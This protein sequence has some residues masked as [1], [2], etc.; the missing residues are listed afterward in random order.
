MSLKNKRK[1][2]VTTG[3]RADYGFLRP[4]LRLITKSKKLKLYLVVTGTHLSK[5]HGCTI[6]EIQKDGFKIFKTINLIP[7]NDTN[8]DMSLA[9]GKGIIYFSK[10]MKTVN[11]DINLI[12]GDR[13]EMLVSAITAYH[14]NIPN[15]HIHGGDKSK[16]GIDEYN[17]H[18]ITKMSNL[19]FAAT[20]KSTQRILKM[21]ENP[22]LVF[23]TGSPVIDEIRMNKITSKNEIEK[24]YKFKLTGDEILL[25]Q[26]PVTTQINQSENQIKNTLTAITKIKKPTIAI[27]PNSDAGHKKIFKYL[28]LYSK[29]YK[30]F[31]LFTNIPHCD[32]LGFLKN[33]GVLVGNS[34]SGMIE[35]SYFNTPVVNIGIRQ[36]GRESGPNVIN[37]SEFKSPLI[38]KAIIKIMKRNR[39]SY[40]N[41]FIYGRGLSAIK[42]VKILEKIKLDNKLIQKQIS[43]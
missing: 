25:V 16:G 39:K 20:K 31:H 12:F 35:G 5:R 27:A 33:C 32:Y 43:M 29:R 24:K 41:S 21:G 2:L 14:L 38:E 37:V 30:F 8:Y 18:A 40:K 42:I 1:I 17:R 34:S 23:L 15:A 28:E 7:K 22:K 6:I 11:P 26:H 13:D 10:L 19:H 4:V 36:T 3:T 9:L